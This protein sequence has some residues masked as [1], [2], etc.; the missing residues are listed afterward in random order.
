[1]ECET[2]LPSSQTLKFDPLLSQINPVRVLTPYVFMIH[3]NIIL[4]PTSVSQL[5]SSS[6][7][8]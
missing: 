3:F 8:T 4:M 6:F 7:L 5:D 1:M 2:L